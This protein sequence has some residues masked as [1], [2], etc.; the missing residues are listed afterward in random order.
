MTLLSL[1]SWKILLLW[2]CPRA[3]CVRRAIRSM[4]WGK[5]CHGGLGIRMRTWSLFWGCSFC[6]AVDSSFVIA[7]DEVRRLMS[8]V[9]AESIVIPVVLTSR[10]QKPVIGSRSRLDVSP[11]G[12]LSWQISVLLI[13]LYPAFSRRISLRRGH[14]GPVPVG[15]MRASGIV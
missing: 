7:K 12:V 3:S 15:R 9:R 4:D 8:A 11:S 1:A 5:E 10:N 6:S 14:F 2:I 13:Q